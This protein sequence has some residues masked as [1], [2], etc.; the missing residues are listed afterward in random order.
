M[1]AFLTFAVF[2][3]CAPLFASEVGPLDVRHHTLIRVWGQDVAHEKQLFLN[4]QLDIMPLAEPGNVQIAA[5]PEQIDQL[6]AQGYG[7]EVIHT[8][9]EEFYAR[10]LQR[11]GNLDLMG[12]YKTYAEIVT[13]MNDLHTNYPSIT[14]APDTIG[15]SL[16]N[17]VIWGMKI[18]DNPNVDENEPEVFYNSLIHAREPAA[19]EAICLFMQTLCQNWASNTQPWLDVVNNR[20]L[21][22]VPCN[23]P[24]G[25]EYNR[26]TNPNGGGMWRKNR[27]NGVGVDL[28]RNFSYLWGID[29]VGSSPTPSSE[30]YRGTGPASEPETQVLQNFINSR[31]F[32]ISINYHTYSNLLLKPWGTSSYQGGFT[33]DDATFDMLIDSMQYFI[34]QYSGAVYAVGAPWELLYNVNG[35][36]D[37]WCYGDTNHTKLFGITPEVGGDADGFWPPQNRIATLAGENLNS[38]L[39]IAR[40]AGSL[41]PPDQMIALVTN[42]QTEITGDG[43]GV[44]EPG[45][46]FALSVTL[47][48]S[49]ALPIDGLSGNLTTADPN[50]TVTD[51]AATWPTLAVNQ[52]AP[53][54]TSFTVNVHVNAPSP[55][56]V[57]F[58]LVLSASTGLDTTITVG[59]VT[60]IPQFADNMESGTNGWTTSGTGSLWH[61]ST[62][63]AQSPTHSWYSG[64][65]GTGLYNDNMNANLVSPSF[66]LAQNAELSFSHYYNLETDFDFGFVEINVGAGWQV[67]AG[68]FTGTSGWSTVHTTLSGFPTGASAQIRFRMFSDAG[69]TA[70]GWYIDDVNVSPPG[71][72]V[73][74]PGSLTVGVNAGQV[75]TRDVILQNTGNSPIVYSTGFASGATADTSAADAYGYRWQDHNGPCGPTFQWRDISSIGTQVVFTTGDQVLGPFTLPFAFPFYGNMYTRFWISANGWVS[76]ADSTNTVFVNVDLP[77]TSAPRAAIFPWWDD[78]KPQLAGTNVRRWNNGV[79]TAIVSYENVQAGTAPNNG[80]YD[81]EVIFTAGGDIRCMYGDMGTIRLQSACIGIQDQTGTIG[82]TILNND[83][84]IGNNQARRFAMGPRYVDVLP[85]AGVLN[86]GE[87]DTL[88][89]RFYGSLLCGDPSNSA[90]NVRSNDPDSPVIPV[91]FTVTSVVAPEVPQ[92]MTISPSGTDIV[93]RWNVAANAT[94]YRIEKA[95]AYDGAYSIL[96]TTASTSFTDVGAATAGPAFYRV[97]ATN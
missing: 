74:T 3:L 76:F 87:I 34:Q 27:R 32:I 13:F 65:E 21:W 89:L 5:F 28:N 50:V 2:A 52:S 45:E 80:T 20:E 62:R 79:D 61:L 58:N 4:D 93:L 38:N 69:V 77:S 81:F 75:A 11:E 83:P 55:A 78:L 82:L 15:L 84:G 59:A 43:D 18:S 14:T 68:P 51:A 9:L 96:G 40:V 31:N 57:Q 72:L 90:L 19:M 91:P 24:D 47:R 36:C 22:F 6:I 44:V 70:E 46:T 53:G 49:G 37:D 10:R 63:R 16:E 97:V 30:T 56:G 8:D 86:G 23:N 7:V 12:G 17:R 85:V 73:V 26:S 48:N 64:N 29:N 1:R 39:F 33:Q 95:A 67:V 54:N 42:S 41:S 71:N 92:S 88:R 66:I 94:G 60:G 25:Y 35:S